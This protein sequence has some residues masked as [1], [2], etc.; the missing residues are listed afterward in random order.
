VAAFIGQFGRVLASSLIDRVRK[1]RSREAAARLADEKQAEESP[2]AILSPAA[3]ETGKTKAS[4]D[5]KMEKKRLKAE[6]KQRKKE[7]GRDETVQGRNDDG[8]E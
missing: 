8:D 1:K 6:I 3:P 7:A 4:A 2:A 5:T